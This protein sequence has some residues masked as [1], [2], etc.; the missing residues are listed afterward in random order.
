MDHVQEGRH[1]ITGHGAHEQGGAEGSAHA[2]AGIG[3]GHREDLE[4]QDQCEEPDGSVPPPVQQ[5]AYVLIALAVKRREEE[6]QQSKAHGAKEPLQVWILQVLSEPV[7]QEERRPQEIEREQAADDSQDQ[8]EGNVPHRKLHQRAGEL[9]G[10]AQQEVGDHRRRHR[11]EQQREDGTHG[12]VEKEDLQREKHTGERGVE[13]ARHGAGRTATQQQRHAPVRQAHVAAQVGADGRPGIDD[14]RL[15]T[16]GTAETDGKRTGK[17]R[18][19]AVVP[20]DLGFV[21]GNRLQ[22]LRHPVADI[23]PHQVTDN[24]QAQEHAD[25]RK[26]QIQ[27]P[28]LPRKGSQTALNG[29]DGEFQQHGGQAAQRTCDHGQHQQGRRLRDL[30]QKGPQGTPDQ[31]YATAVCHVFIRL[32]RRWSTGRCCRREG[33]RRLRRRRRRCH[34]LRPRSQRPLLPPASG[35]RLPYRLS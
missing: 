7:L 5:F 4:N 28:A 15:G 18:T 17:E 25:A 6:N 20:P 33:F 11:G 24:Q 14:G 9:G 34:R 19:P 10:P 26:H 3:E 12:Q 2:A 23:V 30:T 21:L 35:L 16:H 29:M 1:H 13:D 32:P 8:V 27:Q 31:F 22:H